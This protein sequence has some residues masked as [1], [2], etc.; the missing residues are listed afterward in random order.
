MTIQDE[1]VTTSPY[2]A[3]FQLV[4][5]TVLPHKC[6]ACGANATGR[7]EFIDFNLSF[8]YEG[9][10]YLCA[11]CGKQIARLL[12]FSDD[13][14]EEEWKESQEELDNLREKYARVSDDLTVYRRMVGDIANVRALNDLFVKLQSLVGER[15]GSGDS[16]SEEEQSGPFE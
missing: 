16:T 15:E 14:Y 11:N 10:I 1:E 2:T 8:D 9:A 7:D 12:G 3:K 6:V 5:E 4:T 13:T